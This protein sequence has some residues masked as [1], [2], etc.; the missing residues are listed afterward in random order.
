[1]DGKYRKVAMK[2]RGPLAP[3]MTPF[4]EEDK[5][6]HESLRRWV[7]WMVTRDVPV[8]WTTGGTSE[9]LALSDQEVFD[10]T[11]TACEANAG[12]SFMIASTPPLSTVP[13]PP[14]METVLSETE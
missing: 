13:S 4:D 9:M 6:D 10:I 11:L 14:S 2:M 8:L 7:D 1:M 5:V 3:I 12:R